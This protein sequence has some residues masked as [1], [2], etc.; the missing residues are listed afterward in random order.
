VATKPSFANTAFW[1]MPGAVLAFCVF[2]AVYALLA[3]GSSTSSD[4]QLA[5]Y[6]PPITPEML[7]YSRLRYAIHFVWVAL[8]TLFLM[9][10]LHCGIAGGLRDLISSRVSSQFVGIALFVVAFTLLMLFVFFPVSYLTG[11]WL[12]HQFGLSSQSFIDWLG[13]VAKVVGVNLAIEIPL[14]WLVFKA[15]SRFRKSWPYLVFLGSIPVILLLTFAAPLVIDPV[16]NK[17]ELMPANSLHAGID[18]LA[19]QAGL[20]GAPVFIADKHKQTNEVN[21]YVTGLGLSAR[22]VIWDTTLNKLKDDEVLSVVAH[23]LGHYVLKHV[24]WGC[25]VAV[26]ISLLLLPVNLIVTPLLIKNLP[27]RWGVRSLE[28]FAV[29]PVLVLCATLLGFISE[30]LINAYSR[31]VE[32]EADAFGV[33]LMPNKDA[34]ARTFATLAKDNLSAPFPPKLIV[35]WLFSHPPLGERISSALSSGRPK[36]AR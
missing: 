10:F 15:V 25:V 6:L 28:D 32:A 17:I 3:P 27:E 4:A 21:A 8:D 1:L 9:V 33:N 13:D 12:K 30:P 34:F 22:I 5:A 2:F 36:S 7:Q 19:A 23:E 16:F 29:I 11:F 31:Q 20:A 14:W 35:F 24:Y 18:K 26:G